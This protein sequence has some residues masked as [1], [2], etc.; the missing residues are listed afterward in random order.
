[1]SASVGQDNNHSEEKH[2]IERDDCDVQPVSLALDALYLRF[3]PGARFLELVWVHV[4]K[5][6]M[7]SRQG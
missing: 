7:Q 3:E 2:D 6:T 1:M 4:A 5:S